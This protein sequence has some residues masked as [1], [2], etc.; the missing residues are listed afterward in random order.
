MGLGGRS[1]ELSLCRGLPLD[2]GAFELA[3]KDLRDHLLAEVWPAAGLLESA[4]WLSSLCDE[5]TTL[6]KSWTQLESE[7]ANLAQ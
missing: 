2:P 1:I 3:G 6:A 7:I 5:S 4:F